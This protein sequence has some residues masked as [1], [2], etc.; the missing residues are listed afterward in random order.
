MVPDPNVES[1]AY[2]VIKI[3]MNSEYQNTFA[4]NKMIRNLTKDV[5]E[6]MKRVFP[7]VK[8]GEDDTIA[9]GILRAYAATGE[10]FVFIIDEYDV[11]VRE[12]VG[13]E[14][15]QE[16]LSFLNGL[17]KS[18]TLRPAI[19]LAYLTGILP[20]V[21]DKIQSKLNNFEEY[22]ILDAAEL[23]EFVGFTSQE[24]KEICEEYGISFEECRRWY[25]GYRQRGIEIYNPESVVKSVKR[26]GHDHRA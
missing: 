17:F 7:D 24:V 5:I 10:T 16:Y 14:L 21:R 1:D 25:D 3:D 6:E 15:F 4:K 13:E 18:D 12:Q 23:T 20:V 26:P 8:F 22:T 9:K 2:H 19:S 11:L